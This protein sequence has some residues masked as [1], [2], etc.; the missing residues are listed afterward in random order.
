[1]K[2][3][4]LTLILGTLATA[5]VHADNI[6]IFKRSLTE[7][8]NIYSEQSL[9]VPAVG[10][11][12]LTAVTT[13]TSYEIVNLTTGESQRVSYDVKLKKYTIG[14]VSSTIGYRKMPLR[15]A[16]TELWYNASVAT[17]EYSE[18][19]YPINPNPP[20]GDGEVDYVA[21]QHQVLAES[22]VAAPV[23]ITP[24]LTLTVP[25]TITIEG[26]AA[27]Q[28]D[29]LAA[30]DSTAAFVG[31]KGASGITYKGTVTFDQAQSL[32]ANTGA[33]INA[34]NNG[35]LNYGVELVKIALGATYTEAL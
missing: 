12:K 4:F 1:M 34:V 11:K 8:A 17:A 28:F 24:A 20:N 6:A 32:K 3:T 10:N 7:T 29:D 33:P 25:K 15:V 2:A 31:M 9:V 27:D 23:K 22:G 30:Q 18:D 35:T 5:S 21:T 19:S 16:G 13:L 14:G 26:T